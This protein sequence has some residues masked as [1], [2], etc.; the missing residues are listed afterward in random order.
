MS[1]T[2]NAKSLGTT[3][4][5]G[6]V[7]HRSEL[8]LAEG[9]RLIAL[10]QGALAT[11]ALQPALRDP[12]ARA[13]ALAW[14]AIAHMSR[15]DG[16]QA[17]MTCRS[18]TT[19][20][21]TSP[22]LWF[23]LGRAHKASGQT[24]EAAVAYRR[25]LDLDPSYREAMV[26]L[27]IALKAQGQL[28]EAIAWYDR[29]IALHP[30]D[31]A[32]HANR[33]NALALRAER[34]SSLASE[35][36]GEHVE[37]L[38]AQGRAVALDPGNAALHR[39]YGM[40]LRRAHRHREAA[41][42]FQQA[43]TL[44]RTDADSCVALGTVLGELGATSLQAQCYEKWLADNPSNVGVM[45][46][47]SGSLT[48]L[49]EA[50]RALAWAERALALESD[51]ICLMQAANALQQLR[52]VPESLAR[53]RESLE[54]SG[55]LPDLWPTYLLGTNYLVEDPAEVAAIHD[56]FGARVRTAARRA[57]RRRAP[58]DR[59]RL[60]YVSGDFVRHSVAFFMAA[61]LEHREVSRF[62]VF[63][64]HCNARSDHVTE[65]FKSYGVQWIECAGLSD[66]MLARR[67]ADDAI[68]ILVDL[69]GATANSRM[70]M[71]ALAPAP[72]QVSYLGYP[73][74]SGLRSIDFRVT[75]HSI[76]PVGEAEPRSERPLRL[77]RSMFC[78]RPELSPQ[79][80]APAMRPDGAVTFGSFN[81]TAKI[82][83]HTLDLW[84]G[85]LLAVPDSRLLLK[86]ASVAQASVS[87]NIRAYLEARGVAPA[88]VDFYPRC[89][90]D[91][92]HLRM[93][94]Q[95]D[96]AL[97]TFPFNGA[98]TTCEALWMGVPV[99]TL[100]GRTH[101]SRMGASL[102]GAIGRPSW[103]AETDA[104]FVEIAVALA[105]DRQAR[106]DWCA[107]AR[108]VMAGSPL[109]AS[110]SFAREFE[111]LME[112]AWSLRDAASATPI[113]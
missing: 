20:F 22:R 67:I 58:G 45:R 66:A 42:A 15:G 88:R 39:N 32:A 19:E 7:T 72:V 57:P 43:L 37:L 8:S 18:A 111:A 85:A 55:G 78:F 24:R 100:R 96:V 3:P 76:D 77:P 102:L 41:E 79:P 62:E 112:L 28:D 26:S 68:D 113:A 89:A 84:A 31:A 30:A 80:S 83:D 14:L 54:Q 95:V 38:E 59:L 6:A 73:T 11:K 108:A 107:C 29:A 98:T 101:T 93:Y 10:G 51:P 65:R 27:G 35:V 94:H 12:P 9:Q 36:S 48:L 44:D 99:V 64:Y 87:A 92:E 33:A 86:S 97:D 69:A 50:D 82:V 53:A 109:M 2:H 110:S 25:A 23:V 60:G 5:V 17:L 1:R 81:N 13:E 4:L 71:F 61:L 90:D 40:M 106:L 103:I 104:E 21:P 75:D 91:G 63:C 74:R 105:Q 47:L 56:A 16:P 52:R 49:G 34:D 46:A 70:L